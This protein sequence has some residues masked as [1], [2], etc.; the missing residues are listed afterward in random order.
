LFEDLLNAFSAI[1]TKRQMALPRY[2]RV[3]QPAAQ[4][5]AFWR[6]RTKSLSL[7]QQKEEE[8]RLFLFLRF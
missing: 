7:H 5:S 4:S 8:R 3:C 6:D 2:A 1:G